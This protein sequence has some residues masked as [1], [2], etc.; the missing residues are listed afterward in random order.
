[1]LDVQGVGYLVLSWLVPGTFGAILAGK[2]RWRDH[3]ITEIAGQAKTDMRPDGP[4]PSGSETPTG[5]RLL[6]SVQGRRRQGFAR[7]RYLSRWSRARIFASHCD[8][9]Q[10][11][12]STRPNWCSD[13][14]LARG[15]SMN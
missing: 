6:I 11:D 10:A 4:L 2:G 12:G 1:V 3:P 7:W 8:G 9:R 14:S 15:L 5:F 13:Q